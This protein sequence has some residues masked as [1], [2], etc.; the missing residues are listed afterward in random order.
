MHP[1]TSF[2]YTGSPARIHAGVGVLDQLNGEALQLLRET[3]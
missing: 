3:S 2:R 1:A